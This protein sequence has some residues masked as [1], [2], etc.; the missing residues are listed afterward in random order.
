VGIA[1]CGFAVG[2][3]GVLPQAASCGTPCIRRHTSAAPPIS[4]TIRAKMLDKLMSFPQL[5]AHEPTPGCV[6]TLS[7][8]CQFTG[9]RAL[10]QLHGGIQ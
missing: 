8:K 5:I 3:T 4:A 1:P 2:T 9:W 6:K 10:S 7:L